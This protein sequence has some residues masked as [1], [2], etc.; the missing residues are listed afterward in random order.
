MY[1]GAS[2]RMLKA[3]SREGQLPKYFNVLHSKY[4]ISHRAL[5]A[6][7]VIALILFSVFKTWQNLV[8]IIAIFHV[9]SYL[10]GPLAVSKLRRTI[11]KS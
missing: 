2:S 11:P 8:V 9:I 7:A 3:M 6:N 4:C 1:M 10:A 5:F